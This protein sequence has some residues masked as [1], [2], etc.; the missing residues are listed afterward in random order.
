MRVLILDRIQTCKYELSKRGF[1][2][3]ERNRGKKRRGEELRR[4]RV[5][6]DEG[7]EGREVSSAKSS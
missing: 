1:K 6:Y 7:R 4:W 3:A 2:K 5:N